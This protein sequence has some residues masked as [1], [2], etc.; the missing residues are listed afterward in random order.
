MP[1]ERHEKPARVPVIVQYWRSFQHLEASGRY[2]QDPHLAAWRNYY[3]RNART[4]IWHETYLVS[5]GP[6]ETINGNMP[7]SASA[8][9]ADSSP[10]RVQHGSTTDQASRLRRG[11]QHLGGR[12]ELGRRTDDGPGSRPLPARERHG[13]RRSRGRT[14]RPGGADEQPRGRGLTP[15]RG[16]A[17]RGRGAA[18]PSAHQRSWAHPSP[19]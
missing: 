14:K 2:S 6:F 16:A 17:S 1:C 7:P 19:R 5:A 12:G 11:A 10:Y 9:P 8:R 18:A 4:G 13:A 3:R 15:R